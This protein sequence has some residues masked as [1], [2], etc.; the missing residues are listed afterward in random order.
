MHLF[1][2]VNRQEKILKE[3]RKS[4]EMIYLKNKN[5]PEIALQQLTQLLGLND[6]K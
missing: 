4:V 3:C 1:E 5:K 6:K 2:E